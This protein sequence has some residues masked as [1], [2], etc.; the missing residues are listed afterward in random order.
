MPAIIEESLAGL[1]GHRLS[2]RRN[3]LDLA[4]DEYGGFAGAPFRVSEIDQLYA[5]LAAG[6]HRPSLIE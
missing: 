3:F 6:V 5:D 1:S 2:D 4:V